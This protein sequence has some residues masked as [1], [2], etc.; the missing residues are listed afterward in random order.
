MNPEHRLCCRHLIELAA[1]LQGQRLALVGPHAP[2]VFKVS[3]VAQE[4]SGVPPQGTGW[5][6]AFSWRQAVLV[7]E[8]G[9]A[10]KEPVVGVVEVWPISILLIGTLGY[11]SFLT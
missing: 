11:L 10:W 4:K 9:W 6:A 8:G 2:D 3:F 5:G 7:M 1:E